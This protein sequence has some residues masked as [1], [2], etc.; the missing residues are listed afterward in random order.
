MF[1]AREAGNQTEKIFLRDKRLIY[2]VYLLP[3]QSKRKGYYLW[4]WCLEHGRHQG[5]QSNG[6]G[7]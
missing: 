2:R 4:N 5:K 6:S 7:V 1:G 3:E